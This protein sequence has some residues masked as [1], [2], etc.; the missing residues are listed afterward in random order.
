MA[1]CRVGIRQ[2]QPKKC[3]M[4]RLA[5]QPLQPLGDYRA[6]RALAWGRTA[7]RRRKARVEDDKSAIEPG[8]ETIPGIEQDRSRE[9]DS[10]I[11]VGAQ[12]IG[13]P[14]SPRGQ[15]SP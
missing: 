3:G 11:S 12:N 9:G 15:R 7:A 14:G 2:V 10:L 1:G 6:R 4:P 5:A 8:G 13:K